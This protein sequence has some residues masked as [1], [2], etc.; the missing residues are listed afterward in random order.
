[1]VCRYLHLETFP[2]NLFPVITLRLHCRYWLCEILMHL[3]SFSLG[4]VKFAKSRDK[5]V[6]QFT[7]FLSP[8]P[9]IYMEVSL[10]QNPKWAEASENVWDDMR[11]AHVHIYIYIYVHTYFYRR[12][13]FKILHRWQKCIEILYKSNKICLDFI[14]IA[15]FCINT[16]VSL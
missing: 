16:F 8:Q 10:W 1:M 11:N 14:D 4:F 6:N 15:C 13:S 12:G 7:W 5:L 9:S 2:D 3:Y